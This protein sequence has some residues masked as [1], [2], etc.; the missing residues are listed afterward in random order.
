MHTTKMT[1]AKFIYFNESSL[2]AGKKI[3]TIEKTRSKSGSSIR[4]F[5]RK[6][7]LINETTIKL[8]ACLS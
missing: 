7:K 4:R 5:E 1:E 3:T 6:L 2:N 8:I